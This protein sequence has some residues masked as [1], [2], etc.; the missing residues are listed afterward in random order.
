[1]ELTT[2]SITLIAALFLTGLSAGLFYAWEFSVIPGAKR[3][4]DQ[5][6]IETM[7]AVNRAIINPAFM[8]IFFGSMLAQTM[9]LYLHRGTTAF[10]LILSALATYFL[11]TI[12]VT[13][14]GNV[15]LNNGLD[16]LNLKDLSVEEI[17][18]HRSAYEPKWNKLHTVR[19]AFAVL[20]FSLM[21]VSTMLTMK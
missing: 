3:V 4:A 19:T 6:Y 21:L 9:S 11:G 12:L 20:S 1:M 17:N 8:L 13:A 5:T 18:Q 15:P 16:A 10:W 2:K 14:L 7:Q